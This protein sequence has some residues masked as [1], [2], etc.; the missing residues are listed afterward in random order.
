MENKNPTGDV[1][2]FA[3][4]LNELSQRMKDNPEEFVQCEL[5]WISDPISVWLFGGTSLDRAGYFTINIQK[6]SHK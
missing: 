6:V 5:E 3:V 2:Q 4:W 1:L